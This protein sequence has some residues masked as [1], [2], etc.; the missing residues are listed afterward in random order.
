MSARART[1][2]TET[3]PDDER[4]HLHEHDVRAPRPLLACHPRHTQRHKRWPSV[5]VVTCCSVTYSSTLV[6]MHTCCALRLSCC[7]FARNVCPR[8]L[9]RARGM[10]FARFANCIIN[11]GITIINCAVDPA[12]SRHSQ[13][14]QRSQTASK[15][16]A[17]ICERVWCHGDLA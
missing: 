7:C 16:A 2:N 6:V 3:G 15:S 17:V 13:T 8:R 12:C 11:L 9:T 14:A 5:S 10:E 4:Q 1:V